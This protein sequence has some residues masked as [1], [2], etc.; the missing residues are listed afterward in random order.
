MEI[1]YHGV[2]Q[3]RWKKLCSACYRCYEDHS[4]VSSP[5]AQRRTT[6][7]FASYTLHV[8]TNECMFVKTLCAFVESIV[9]TLL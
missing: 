9:H 7:L 4:V 3:R 2:L 8:M 1:R 6:F 5:Q